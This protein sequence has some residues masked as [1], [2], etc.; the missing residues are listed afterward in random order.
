MAVVNPEIISENAPVEAIKIMQK[1]PKAKAIIPSI[2][3]LFFF[4][5]QPRR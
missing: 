4:K 1:I 3:I 5:K 2:L